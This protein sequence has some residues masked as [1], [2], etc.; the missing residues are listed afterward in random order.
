MMDIDE[1]LLDLPSWTNAKAAARV[2]SG[3]ARKARGR[4]SYIDP[5]ISERVHSAEELEFMEAM[6][7]YKASAGRMFPT[8]SE[9]LEVLRGLGY[10]KAPA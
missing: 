4:V 2:T 6:Q 3:A 1:A 8:W 10:E 9:T 7:E 5:T